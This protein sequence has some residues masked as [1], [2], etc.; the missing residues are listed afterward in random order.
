MVLTVWYEDQRADRPTVRIL[1]TTV[2]AP[3]EQQVSYATSVNKTCEVVRSWLKS[4]VGMDSVDVG[5][6]NL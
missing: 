4:M 2:S 6:P 1:R 3:E 5:P